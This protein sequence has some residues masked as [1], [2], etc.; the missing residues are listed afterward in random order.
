MSKSTLVTSFGETSICAPGCSSYI[1]A[2]YMVSSHA[3]SYGVQCT[4]VA[5][6]GVSSFAILSD[7][8]G[9]NK[10]VSTGLFML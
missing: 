9:L 3:G 8:L 10:R 6:G 7:S 5:F 1:D 2:I 4:N